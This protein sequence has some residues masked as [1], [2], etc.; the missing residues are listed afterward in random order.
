MA[1]F[2]SAILQAINQSSIVGGNIASNKLLS[3]SPSIQACYQLVGFAFCLGS[4]LI[5]GIIIGVIMKISH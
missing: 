3:R 4:A 1:S 5:A 2:M